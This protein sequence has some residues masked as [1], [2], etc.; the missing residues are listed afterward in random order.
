MRPVIFPSGIFLKD[1][2]SSGR[3]YFW[4]VPWGLTELLRMVRKE[5]PPYP[6]SPPCHTYAWPQAV[7][8]IQVFGPITVLD[9]PI[10][11][12]W[13]VSPN[14]CVLPRRQGHSHI[15]T[16]SH[17]TWKEGF[18]TR[19]GFNF[20]SQE[21]QGQQ[22]PRSDCIADQWGHGPLHRIPAFRFRLH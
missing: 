19:A 18:H 3:R 10:H 15:T 1:Y 11:Y 2:T 16:G 13:M 17:H 8:K 5:T 21:G 20:P 14:S 4:K 22:V 9:K 7:P 12:H 6:V